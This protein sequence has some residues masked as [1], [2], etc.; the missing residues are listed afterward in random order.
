M[1]S[2]NKAKF[3]SS[4]VYIWIFSLL[5]LVLAALYL[6]K[7][8]PN[9][10]LPV[11]DNIGY[12]CKFNTKAGSDSMSPFLKQ[13]ETYQ[14]DK[15]FKPNE[16]KE[17]LIATYNANGTTRIGI[18]RT[19]INN[20]VEDIYRISNERDNTNVNSVLSTDIYGVYQADTS[21][22]KYTPEQARDYTENKDFFNQ[23]NL[24]KIPLS[25]DVDKDLPEKTNSFSKKQDKFCLVTDSKKQILGY[26]FVIQN[27]DSKKIIARADDQILKSGRNIDCNPIDLPAGKYTIIGTQNHNQIYQFDFSV[28]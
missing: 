26:G 13:N 14:F 4:R 12:L 1:R 6:Y 8:R 11:L 10:K 3:N 28:N 15:C 7:E 22:S 24:A 21:T 19:I 20:G 25:G 27:K 9:V 18:I 5:I 16:L 23:V 2:E 17:G